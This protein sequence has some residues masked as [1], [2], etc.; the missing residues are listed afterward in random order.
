MGARRLR[1]VWRPEFQALSDALTD[2]SVAPPLAAS[3]FAS[4]RMRVSTEL[5]LSSAGPALARRIASPRD[6]HLR[7]GAFNPGMALEESGPEHAS[8]LLF[9]KM[10][11][12]TLCPLRSWTLQQLEATFTQH[13]AF[14]FIATARVR[15]SRRSGNVSA[16]SPL[17][18]FA[19][20]V[21]APWIMEGSSDSLGGRVEGMEDMRVLTLANAYHQ[22]RRRRLLFFSAGQRTSLRWRMYFM[23]HRAH[24]RALPLLFAEE[25][26]AVAEEEALGLVGPNRTKTKNWSPFEGR[27]GQV[28][29]EHT[30][31]P[32]A[33]RKVLR[34]N[35]TTGVCSLLPPAADPSHPPTKRASTVSLRGSTPPVHLPSRGIYLGLGHERHKMKSPPTNHTPWPRFVGQYLHAF[36]AFSDVEPFGLLSVGPWIRLPRTV[37]ATRRPCFATGLVRLSEETLG[38]SYGDMDCLSALAQYRGGEIEV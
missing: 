5:L 9:F 35:V 11:S 32:L 28:Y 24:S 8:L 4:S 21:Q 25:E 20:S 1:P 17:R 29:L 37:F 33:K 12:Y 27:D 6:A 18:A 16:V 15:W 10:S 13:G 14:S 31:A 22:R 23:E 7:V 26:A 2:L 38:V 30:I 19:P 34:L 3:V 36:Y